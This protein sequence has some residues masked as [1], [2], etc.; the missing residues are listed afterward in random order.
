MASL[1]S[2][3]VRSSKRRNMVYGDGLNDYLREDLMA[4]AVGEVGECGEVVSSW[5][6]CG[7]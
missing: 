7:P 3:P 2:G 5:R 4:E 6:S 1:A